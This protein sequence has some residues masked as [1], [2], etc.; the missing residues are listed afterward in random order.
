MQ[1][2]VGNGAAGSLTPQDDA[3]AR[4]RRA[5]S[6]RGRGDEDRSRNPLYGLRGLWEMC[7]G[8]LGG[9]LSQRLRLDLDEIPLH[10]VL[11]NT[12]QQYL[13]PEMRLRDESVGVNVRLLWNRLDFYAPRQ[14]D[15]MVRACAATRLR[16]R[17]SARLRLRRCRR[18]AG[19]R[20]VLSDF[21]RT[22]PFSSLCR[23]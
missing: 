8:G 18:S 15:G 23:A 16:L 9:G 22:R 2:S 4:L 5:E 12:L 13:G 6:L 20:I 7:G 17:R 19:L 3:V 10:A 21:A 11:C 14:V 1:W